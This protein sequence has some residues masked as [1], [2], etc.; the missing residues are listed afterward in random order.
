MGRAVGSATMRRFERRLLPFSLLIGLVAVALANQSSAAPPTAPSVQHILIEQPSEWVPF[1]ADLRRIQ[2]TDGTV[3]VGRQYR[4]SNGSTRNETGPVD[5]GI[6]SIAINNVAQTTFYRWTPQEGW[7][8]QPMTLPPWGW[9]PA[10]TVFN[11]KMT[12]EPS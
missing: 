2:E 9:R 6:N 12:R 10:P 3:F 8:S 11:E 1:S 4:S 7:T 5:G